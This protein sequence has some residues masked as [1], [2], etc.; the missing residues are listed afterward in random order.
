[1][2][3]IRVHVRGFEERNNEENRIESQRSVLSSLITAVLC[4]GRWTL[5]YSAA[6]K[7]KR[8]GRMI[9]GSI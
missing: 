3:M 7:A 4:E 5:R 2:V 6:E 8:L 9:R 1:M